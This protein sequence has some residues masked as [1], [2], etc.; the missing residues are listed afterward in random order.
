MKSDQEIR[1]EGFDILFKN[2]D[3]VEAERFIALINR[4][5][6]DYTKWRQ[7]LFENMTPEEIIAEG[8]KYA[9]DFRKIK[10]TI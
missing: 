5:R 10:G 8:R 6:F 2:M 4:D 9:I 7:P 1:R 3:N